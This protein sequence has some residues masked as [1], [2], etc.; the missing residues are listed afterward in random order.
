MGMTG[1][2][3]T[4]FI[5]LCTGEPVLENDGDILQSCKHEI[6]ML[7]VGFSDRH[8][9]PSGV[10][11]HSI[12]C[13]GKTVHLIDTPGFDDTNRPDEDVFQEL[14][15]WMVKSYKMNVRIGGIVYL[16]RVTDPRVQGSA[17]RALRIFKKTC[18]A[19]NYA[20]IVLATTRWD[21]V[22][23]TVGSKRV[24]ELKDKPEFWG[25]MV[26][27]G[28]HVSDTSAGRIS[29]LKIVNYFATKNK[30]YILQLQKEMVDQDTP[31][32]Q[33]GAGQILYSSWE[34]EKDRLEAQAKTTLEQMREDVNVHYRRRSD[35][36]Q[37]EMN[38]LSQDMTSRIKA[39]KS[40]EAST[41]TLTTLWDKR[42]EDQMA[43]IRKTRLETEQSLRLREGEH[44]PWSN[45]ERS[46][47]LGLE[48]RDLKRRLHILKRSESSRAQTFTILFGGTSAITGAIS[49][50]CA[51][52]PLVAPLALVACT[53][54]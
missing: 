31:L 30:T 29:A 40:L 34:L 28:S 48:I 51:I 23:S 5:S 47:Q 4:R 50:A 8:S 33:T 49:A 16:H 36:L 21:E 2:G 19:D 11:L 14:A 6:S 24:R 15:Y 17:L 32:H 39:M 46:L 3:K 12:Q 13:N 25:E 9:G 45:D 10:S 35:D 54:M 43:V 53:I 26:A 52:L 41:D 42:T 18:G 20:G 38:R 1:A 37:T 7:K 44:H 27:G 22:N